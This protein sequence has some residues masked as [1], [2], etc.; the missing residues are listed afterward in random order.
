MYLSVN[1]YV[2]GCVCVCVSWISE[3]VLKLKLQRFFSGRRHPYPHRKYCACL[4]RK[5]KRGREQSPFVFC[6]KQ[7]GILSGSFIWFQFVSTTHSLH[8]SFVETVHIHT[9]Y[10]EGRKEKEKE[11]RER[12]DHE[13]GFFSYLINPETKIHSWWQWQI[14]MYGYDLEIIFGSKTIFKKQT[15]IQ[16]VFFCNGNGIK[17]TVD[18]T[19]VDH[20][21][22]LVTT[23]IF[24]QKKII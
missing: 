13:N 9:N 16:N 22:I 7:I 19:H 2:N 10:G 23:T 15:N 11:R 21:V 3:C 4:S 5:E 20:E 12:W 6:N 1:K 8:N 24:Q 14:I 17:V 18:W